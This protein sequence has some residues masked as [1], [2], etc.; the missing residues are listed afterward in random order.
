MTNNAKVMEEKDFVK[1]LKAIEDEYLFKDTLSMQDQD[2]LLRTDDEVLFTQII[3]RQFAQRCSDFT[4]NKYKKHENR[5]NFFGNESKYTT[6]S[7][8]SVSKEDVVSLD[9]S[10]DGDVKRIKKQKNLYARHKEI[11]DNY[12]AFIANQKEDVVKEGMK[13]LFES[14][15]V[16]RVAFLQMDKKYIM[17]KTLS[18]RRQMKKQSEKDYQSFRDCL[19]KA[20]CG[21]YSYS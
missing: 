12:C 4:K 18:I 21:Y 7:N 14:L 8:I 13:S 11:V 20:I 16:L 3:S 6:I 17:L 2:T 9:E 15:K 19:I 10:D 5:P 1:V